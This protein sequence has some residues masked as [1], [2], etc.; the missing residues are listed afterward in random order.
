MD[1]S[2]LLILSQ[3]LLDAYRLT[4]MEILLTAPALV[5]SGRGMFSRTDYSA[6]YSICQ[7]P[8]SEWLCLCFR[9][10]VQNMQ[11]LWICCFV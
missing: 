4:V 10:A 1:V 6:Q 8:D 3:L 2:V 11:T 5:V 7:Q 9:I